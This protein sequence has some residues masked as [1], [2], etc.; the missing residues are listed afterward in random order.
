[1]KKRRDALKLVSSTMPSNSLR[2]DF[3]PSTVISALISRKAAS[4]NFPTTALGL[5]GE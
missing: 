5:D 3:Y 1:M 4:P 2:I